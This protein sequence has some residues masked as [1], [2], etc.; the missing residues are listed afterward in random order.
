VPAQPPAEPAGL[1]TAPASPSFG[2][3]ARYVI[4]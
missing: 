4:G 2:S 3:W 1:E